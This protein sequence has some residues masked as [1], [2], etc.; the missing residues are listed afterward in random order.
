MNKD[1]ELRELLE[2][3]LRQYAKEYHEEIEVV[4]DMNEPLSIEL[5]GMV[6]TLVNYI[7]TNY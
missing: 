3:L 2:D 1:Q 4:M 7:K 6:D 5:C